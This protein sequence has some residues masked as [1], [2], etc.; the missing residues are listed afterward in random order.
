MVS[1]FV[2]F[3]LV[4][5]ILFDS[6]YSFMMHYRTAT[7]HNTIRL[8]NTQWQTKAQFNTTY[9]L[10]FSKFQK[11]RLYQQS[12]YPCEGDRNLDVICLLQEY[13]TIHYCNQSVL[14]FVPDLNIFV[15]SITICDFILRSALVQ[16]FSIM[17]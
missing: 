3:R 5:I 7:N 8:I 14:A 4:L 6:L 10:S 15:L 17:C 16:Y 2:L 9:V 11:Q 12:A 1:R 13:M